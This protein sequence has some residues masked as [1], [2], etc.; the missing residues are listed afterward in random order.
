MNRS[1]P[2]R[3]SMLEESQPTEMTAAAGAGGTSRSTVDNIRELTDA[4]KQLFEAGKQLTENLSE[5]SNRM[6]HASNVGS[7]VLKSPWLLAGSAV[8]AGTIL[9]ALSRRH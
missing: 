5:L 2:R 1:T 4:S 8:I 7:Q 3:I 6:E 9:I